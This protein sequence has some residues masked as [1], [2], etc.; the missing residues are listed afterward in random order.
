MGGLSGSVTYELLNGNVL[1]LSFEYALDIHQPVALGGLENPEYA[2]P[3]L[4]DRDGKI[5]VENLAYWWGTRSIPSSRER[6][7]QI[8]QDLRVSCSAELAEKCLGMT[9]SDRYWVRE[10]GS[11]VSWG[12]VNFFENDFSDDLGYVTLEGHS[13]RGD[14]DLRSPSSSVAGDLKKKWV[15]ENG[16]RYLVKGGSSLFAQEPFNEVAA[17]SLYRRVLRPGEYVPYELIDG[18]GETYC[19]CPNM[20]VGDEE[21]VTAWDL[22]YRYRRDADVATLPR[23]LTVLDGLGLADARAELSKVFVTDV[24]VANPD[25]HFRNFGVIRDSRTLKYTRFAPIFDSGAGFWCRARRLRYPSDY[26]YE[27]R[28]FLARSGASM[29]AARQLRLFDDCAWLDLSSLDGWRE[30]ALDILARNELISPA[31]LE[32]I[33]QGITS[34]IQLVCAHLERMRAM[35]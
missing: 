30:E 16:T 33:S 26:D 1:V 35:G 8:L 12:D 31:R 21:L 17:T 18:D 10:R 23:L 4:F 29:D 11:D 7:D 25:R 28:P 27:T 14:V 24:L 20:L 34:Q 22:L 2:P 15:I 32:Q 3:I 13:P 19:R 5:A 9:L 6:F